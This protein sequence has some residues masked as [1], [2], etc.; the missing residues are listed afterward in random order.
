MLAA[1]VRSLHR[2]RSVSVSCAIRVRSRKND[3][4]ETWGLI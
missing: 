2:V 1:A 3:F 4:R